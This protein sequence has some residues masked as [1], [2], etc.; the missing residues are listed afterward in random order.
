[1]GSFGERLRKEREQRGITLDDVSLSTKIGTRMLRALEEEQFDQLPG[2]IFN[3]GFV[4][5]YARHLGIDEQQAVSDYLEAAGESISV[6]KI[7]AVAQAPAERP[8][9]VA[10]PPPA[11]GRQDSAA[12]NLP[13][14]KLA[15]VLLLVALGLS[16]WSY[17]TRETPPKTTE[18]QSPATSPGPT[19]TASP[20]SPQPSAPS[21]NAD[22]LPAE[23]RSE[24]QEG[25]V[26]LPSSASPAPEAGSS[27]SPVGGS[28]PSSTPAPVTT[29]PA[30][31]PL[32]TAA[33][34]PLT[35]ASATAPQEPPVPPGLFVVQI[36]ADD[37][38]WLSIT[39]DGK[40][41]ETT[42]IA[43]ARKSILAQKQIVIRAGNV[44][45]LMFYFNG[46][47]LPPQGEEGQVKTLIFGADGLRPPAP[48]PPS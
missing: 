15:I 6:N 47:K 31:S 17:H 2:G 23:T 36:I 28:Q 21:Q 29:V 35:P 16:L 13:W 45:A 8:K 11:V 25:P 3:K 34:A 30:K 4:R 27:H 18:R 39:A 12:A 38:C 41:T 46:K 37:D 44:G 14:G 32:S 22:S 33:K 24:G 40:A 5:A 9:P 26:A 19:E 20:A 7:E 43:P 48:K 10:P 42:L 1:M